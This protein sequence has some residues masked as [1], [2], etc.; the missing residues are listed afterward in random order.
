MRKPSIVLVA[1]LIL[2]PVA[3][4]GLSDTAAAQAT[5]PDGQ[6]RPT[7]QL[8]SI[9]DVGDALWQCWVPPPLDKSRPGTQITVLITFNRNGEV[10][11]EPRFTYITPGIPAEIRTAYQLSVA[12]AISRC[13]PLPFTP[14]LG[15]ALAGRPFAMRYD[16]TRGQKGADI[17][18]LTTRT[19]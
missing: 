18:W 10:M 14:A 15:G 2:G 6:P 5:P 3:C 1:G 9:K 13:A 17:S 4:A 16:D 12:D 8:N 19:S 7:H 11:G